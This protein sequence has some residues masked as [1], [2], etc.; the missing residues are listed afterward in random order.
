MVSQTPGYINKFEKNK[1]TMSLMIKD[2]QLFKK[3]NKI[4]KKIEQLMKIDF[5]TKTTYGDDD[6]FVKTKIKTH[7]DSIT[8]N[9][10]NKKGSEKIPKEKVPHKCL[11]IIILD[12][13]IYAYEKYYPQIFLEECKY[14]KENIKTKNYI[15]KELKSESKSEFDIDTDTN[16]DNNID[17]DNEE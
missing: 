6:K 1:I 5:N 11:S 8:T 4:W 12:S 7:R 15:D 2:I 17:I 10:Y 16:S 13:I 14:A 3:Y 9:F